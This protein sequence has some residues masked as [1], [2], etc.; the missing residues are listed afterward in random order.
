MS[1]Q[2]KAVLFPG[3]GSQTPD[4]RQE[5][6]RERP[7]LLELA[8]D[9]VGD[10]P[11]ARVEEGTQFAQPA[12]FCASM[13]AWARV[14]SPSAD[15]FAGHSMGELAAL[16]AAGSLDSTEA[17]RLVA[18]RGRL[19]AKA[20]AESG[21]GGML[22]L[23]SKR[24]GPLAIEVGERLASEFRLTVAND[25]SPEQVVL[26]GPTESLDRA[27]DAASS[28][29]LR[30]VR[31]SVAGAFHSP[32]MEPVVDEF[33]A[34][35]SDVDF[36]TPKS[37]VLSSALAAPFDDVRRRLAEGLTRPVR[38]RETVLELGRR[39]VGRFIEVGPGKVLTGLVRRTL[40]DAE[41][42]T[43]DQMEAVSA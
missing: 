17:L 12:I 20:A 8:I 11:F 25:N 39:G 35:L 28:E 18:L 13:A 14:G 23:M 26:S 10:D 38:W 34:A 16:A 41:A 4:M 19:M 7:D 27:A 29:G 42:V 21:E 6:E 40:P 1:Q 9:E 5:V 32:A 36:A 15:F 2:A 22:A 33:N 43:G 30:S 31:L 24:G 3:Q 37:L